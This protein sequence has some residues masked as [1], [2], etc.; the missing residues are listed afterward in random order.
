MSIRSE[1]MQSKLDVPLHGHSLNIV[2]RSGPALSDILNS[3]FG[4]V[5]TFDG[6]DFEKH[7]SIAS[8][9]VVPEKRFAATLPNGVEVD[10]WKADL[11][12]FP[13]DAVV[14]AA[15]SSLHHGG[16]LAQALSE[17]G[18][19]TIQKDSYDYISKHG[20]LKTGETFVSAPGS[21]PCKKIIHAVGPHL[22]YNP[23]MSDV[24]QAEPLLK[25]TICSILDKVEEHGF[26]TVAIPAISSGLF[27]YP[28]PDCANTI[29][30]TVKRYYEKS[31][32][33]THRPPK[34][35]LVNHDEPT[36]REMERACRQIFGKQHQP[37]LYSQATASR[38]RSAAKTSTP[39]VQI[40]NV[41]L[42]VKRENIEEQRTDVIVNT[43]SPHRDLSQG[44]ISKVLLQKAGHKMQD[45]LRFAKMM[46]H[47]IPTKSYGLRCREV[48]HTFCIDKDLPKA[49]KIL[50][51]SVLE[52]LQ[53]A[54]QSQ[55]QS[56]AFPAIGT[57][58]LRFTKEESA[59]IM[60]KAVITFAQTCRKKMEVYFVIFPSDYDTFQAFEEQIGFLQQ[61]LSPASHHSPTPAAAASP[62][63]DD[64][65][66]SKTPS[67]QISLTGLSDE[68]TREAEKWLTHLL[69]NSGTVEIYNNFI[70]HLSETEYRQLARLKKKGVLIEEFLAN[71]H[72]CITIIGNSE[73]VA[74][75][76]L[77]VEAMLCTVQKKFVSEEE[78]ELQTL[79][80]G[81]VF[82]ERE[83]VKRES[84]EFADKVTAF[85]NVGLRITKVDKVENSALKLLFEL[86]KKQLDCRTS[87]RMLQRI[88]AQFCEMVSHIG[89][90]AEYAPPEDPAY[91]E[92]IYFTDK[93]KRAMTMWKARNE[94]YLYFV[95][96]DVLKGNS[97]TG[98]RDLIVPPTVG[99]DPSILYDSVTGGSDVSVIFSGYQALPRY[100]IICKRV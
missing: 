45:E 6:V 36:V 52:C 76:A 62:H 26:M 74:V 83:T 90:H 63:R 79:T 81:K 30:S 35:L 44:Q 67:P 33:Q 75:A 57:G 40:G 39:T 34:I 31:S 64:L 23:T 85:K 70:Q 94:E 47:A 68:S 49:N 8:P 42:K 96:A 50:F 80:A 71:G 61:N 72:A 86:K 24:T 91:G 41:V 20:D 9:T 16:G 5:A 59:S 92:G 93:V 32:R 53:R 88:P 14:N 54:E 95:E 13:V 28:L 27:N 43:A 2:K 17:A 87:Q 55:H 25:T 78:S 15:N 11:T 66:T 56:I 19:P 29:V 73:D 99:T 22:M 77:Q 21:L 37:M 98:R 1:T 82:F 65:P 4:C 48:Y 3:K 58:A 7:Q 38:T 97:T 89:F 10:V 84:K 69:V 100:I 60:L 51:K 18:G 12:S 46:G